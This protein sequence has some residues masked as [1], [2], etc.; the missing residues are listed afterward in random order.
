MS[1]TQSAAFGHRVVHKR[2][3]LQWHL[4][5]PLGNGEVG[6]MVWGDG[7]PLAFTLDKDDLW[8]LRCNTEYAEHPDFTY[9]SLVE[10]VTEK[11]FDELVEI[12]E[13]RQRRDNP[14]GPTKVSIGRAE[15]RLG[16]GVA[17][18]CGLALGTAT[19][20][21]VV[22]T[23]EG[24][25]HLQSFV[26][27]DRNVFC[28]RL[29]ACRADAR[30]ELIPLANMNEELLKL[31]H[32]RPEVEEDGDMRIL[33]QS[34]PEGLSY[35]VAWNP[36]GADFFV[37]IESGESGDEARSAAVG[38]WRQA[39][40][41]GFNELL[42]EH[43]QAWNKFWSRSAVY[44][45]EERMEFLWY[46]GLYLLASSAR[47]GSMPPGL[48]GVWAVDGKPAPWRGDYH[49]DMNVQETF[50]P[51]CASGHLDLL[52]CWC[53]FMYECL[54]P[55]QE[56][57]RRF[58]GT[59]GAFWPCAFLPKFTVVP[60]WG[61]VQL[62][63]SSS[64][65]L[66]WLVWL[67]WRHSLDTAW[68]AEIGYPLV[69]EIF[70]FYRANLNEEDDGHLHIPVSSSPEYKDNKPE[71]WC[72]DPN[73]D[74]ALIRK[75]CD[76]VVEM[77]VALGRDDLSTA[78]RNVHAKLM[79]YHLTVGKALCL[80]KEQP[81][82]E[83]HRHPSQL[84]AIH[85]AMDLT[86]DD[87]EEARAIIDASLEQFFSL[88]QQLWAGHTYGQMASLAAVVGR[89]EFAYDCLL[90]F[91]EYWVAPNGMHFNRDLRKTGTTAFRGDDLQFTMET[92]CGVS[93]G[94]S[95]MLVQGW[96]DTVRVFPAVPGHWRELA[97]RD[98][99]TEGA[100]NVSAIRRD[101]RTV[102]VRV[103]ATVDRGL[104]LMNPFDGG[105][106]QVSGGTLRR[107]G[108]VFVGDLAAGQVVTLALEGES[109]D[110]GGAVKAVRGSDTSR[111][112]LR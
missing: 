65:W 32:P 90:H 100:F 7:N 62:A 6:V 4:G 33:T 103:E 39:K 46:H 67:R 26:H 101:R 19:V 27:R 20:E 59:E 71:A 3:P 83:S 98:L 85:P 97:F 99:L 11:R 37:A 8:D 70:K 16:E 92:N 82:D 54:E 50:W 31:N 21:G 44:L 102:W 28:L 79:P 49:T 66:A 23:S 47:R 22:R 74:I 105:A 106:V 24:E 84:M 13:H 2:A 60:G 30:L 63:W 38:T 48:Q 77:E 17:Y 1:T 68:L 75:C 86:V 76:W 45:P 78:A 25:H 52:D 35:A 51:A 96:R 109:V 88:G 56:L 53:D 89:A 91:A 111:L 93:A 5:F 110:L 94:I 12:F 9:A 34:I 81:L 73:I 95:D 72:K 64:G 57:T 87:G 61:T 58:F 29:D 14:M 40:A 10:H 107:E 42:R 43:T 108:D 55:A 18:E 80:W 15:L 36:V 41:L 69:S 104:R 112:G